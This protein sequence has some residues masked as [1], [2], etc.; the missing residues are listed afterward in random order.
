MDIK[1]LLENFPPKERNQ[2]G[3][4]DY[5][6]GITSLGKNVIRNRCRTYMEN[7]HGTKANVKS[8][9][10]RFVTKTY[11]KGPLS[12]DGNHRIM[13]S[14]DHHG[15]LLDADAWEAHLKVVEDNP[16]DEYLLLGDVIDFPWIG[17][18]GKALKRLNDKADCFRNYS[19]VGEVEYTKE[20]ILK[21]LRAATN[22]KITLMWGN[23][24]ERVVSPGNFSRDQLAR[25]TELHL[26]Y[27][28][29]KLEEMLELEKI[30]IELHSAPVKTYFN[31]WN[32]VHGL[33]V[34]PTAAT[35]N[36]IEFDGSGV[37]GHTHRLNSNF[38]TRR[39]RTLHWTE[40]GTMR[41]I[42]EVEYFP[43]GKIPNWAQGYVSCI[44][45]KDR[46]TF[47]ADTHLIYDGETAFNGK[48]YSA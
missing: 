40:S 11:L 20:H 14:S 8:I 5:L 47:F 31:K 28:T 6:A 27:N 33:T 36:I 10:D 12:T 13:V 22:A 1:E 29:T 23:H 30:G 44:F 45:N 16:I 37:S 7:E 42:E 43:T 48:I 38:V 24:C 26:A 3:Y 15:W 18:H 32:A 9:Y 34:S 39:G 35:K 2:R 17:R 21:P 46:S 25:L 41:L 4:W 19:E